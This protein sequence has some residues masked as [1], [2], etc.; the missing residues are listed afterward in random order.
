MAHEKTDPPYRSFSL[1]L[2][3]ISQ[4]QSALGTMAV[5]RDSRRLRFDLPPADSAPQFGPGI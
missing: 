4:L 2:R 3:A 1:E 5:G